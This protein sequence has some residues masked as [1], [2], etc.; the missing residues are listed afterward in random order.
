MPNKKSIPMHWRK[1][2]EK[3]R[4]MGGFCNSC[5]KTYF[6]FRTICSVCGEN[7]MKKPLNTKGEII[8]FTTI[9]VAPEGFEE[10]YNIALIKL[11]DVI[12]PGEIVGKG[13]DLEI[14]K[15]VEMIFRKTMSNKTGIIKYGFKFKICD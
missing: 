11:D 1:Q 3:Y 2:E 7:I 10:P 12:V 14:G 8:T 4:L 9:H 13:E 5:K 15:K 6:P